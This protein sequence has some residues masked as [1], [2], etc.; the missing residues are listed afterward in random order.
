MSVT[1]V[2]YHSAMRLWYEMSETIR[3]F[4][5]SSLWSCALVTF[6]LISARF[7]TVNTFVQGA[8]FDNPLTI[9]PC[10]TCQSF[11]NA[12]TCDFAVFVRALDGVAKGPA[13][14]RDLPFPV[15]KQTN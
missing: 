11:S 7:K 1:A 14:Y 8:R 10:N 4:E 2:D 12:S 15:P 13:T 3:P 5:T 6:T 9:R